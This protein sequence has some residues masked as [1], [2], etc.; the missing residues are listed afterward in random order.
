MDSDEKT[1]QCVLDGDRSRFRDL[2]RRYE[3]PVIG[4]VRNFIN[5]HHL[6]EDVAQE[7]FVSAFRKLDS[8]D[9]A[10]SRFSTWLFTIARNRSIDVLRKRKP[11]FGD[12]PG[13][14]NNTGLDKKPGPD[15]RP[16]IEGKPALT[17]K[18]MERVERASPEAPTLEKEFFQCLDKALDQLS[19]K[20]KTAFILIE[21]EGLSYEE[22]SRIEG[23]SMGTIKSRV[24]RAKENLRNALEDYKGA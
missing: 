24:H 7:I 3:R 9:A 20:L 1:V 8:F 12:K 11:E 23:V 22:A 17:G 14:D 19:L 2:V 21:L 16:G 15:N 5:D 4:M 18:P 6:A 13:I 10:Q